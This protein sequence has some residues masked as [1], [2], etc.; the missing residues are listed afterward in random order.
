MG[1]CGSQQKVLITLRLSQLH[2][3]RAFVRSCSCEEDP[4]VRVATGIY[5]FEL[6]IFGMYTKEWLDQVIPLCEHGHLAFHQP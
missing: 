6:I 1:A 4:I 2:T 5:H 3:V